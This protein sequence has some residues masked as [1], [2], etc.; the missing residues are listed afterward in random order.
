MHTSPPPPVPAAVIRARAPC[1]ESLQ[2]DTGGGQRERSAPSRLEQDQTAHERTPALKVCV[3]D[4]RN[5]H[6]KND[7]VLTSA[8][9][10]YWMDADFGPATGAAVTGQELGG[11][12][13]ACWDT[14]SAANSVMDERQWS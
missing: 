7:L 11:G 5:I 12:Q 10:R 9:A 1:R 8:D 3:R 4:L 2:W 6:G 14:E 13:G